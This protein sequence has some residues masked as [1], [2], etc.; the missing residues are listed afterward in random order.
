M[1][2]KHAKVQT[3]FRVKFLKHRPPSKATLPRNIPKYQLNG[4]SLILKKG[5]SGR[6]VTDRTAENIQV[7]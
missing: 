3:E 6:S 2:Q 5:K 7:V 4:T 1:K